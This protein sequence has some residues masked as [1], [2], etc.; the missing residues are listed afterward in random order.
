MPNLA[1]WYQGI[2]SDAKLKKHLKTQLA[3]ERKVFN[4]EEVAAKLA[5]EEEKAR[6]KAEKEAKFAAKKAAQANKAPAK[7]KPAK[8]E[9]KKE[10]VKDIV[11]Y[12]ENT[13]AGEKKSTTCQLPKAYSPKV[14]FS[15]QI[16][17]PISHCM[18][19]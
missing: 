19:S 17:T 6:K 10:K 5:K 13:A 18:Y 2:S 7:A 1:A 15:I 3:K 16:I 12:T 11:E 8:K 14:E 9:E 4:A